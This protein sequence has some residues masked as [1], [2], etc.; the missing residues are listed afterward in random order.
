MAEKEEGEYWWRFREDESDP[1]EEE[2]DEGKECKRMGVLRTMIAMLDK[3]MGVFVEFIRVSKSRDAMLKE[4]MA[5]RSERGLVDNEINAKLGEV[6]SLKTRLQSA[7]EAKDAIAQEVSDSRTTL[8]HHE[9]G[10]FGA[11]RLLPDKL[12]I[13]LIEKE[14]PTE[15]LF[16]PQTW[17]S[18]DDEE[19]AKREG[20]LADMKT[21]GQI[22]DFAVYMRKS[23]CEGK[24]GE[25]RETIGVLNRQTVGLEARARKAEAEVAKQA[26]D[27][28]NREEE[29]LK[30]DQQVDGL[31]RTKDMLEERLAAMEE[32]QNERKEGD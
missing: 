15:S 27:I 25:L 21:Q 4:L 12:T 9:T 10:C 7:I 28:E 32:K 31:T 17:T 3:L 11:L 26:K 14:V 22:Q 30:L 20:Q 13:A 6:D 18:D 1:G 19:F 8:H 23:A 2:P 5:A 24:V 29:L 16:A